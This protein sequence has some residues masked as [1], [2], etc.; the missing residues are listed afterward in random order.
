[1]SRRANVQCRLPL[2]KWHLISLL[3]FYIH[4]FSI[5]NE[6]TKFW[7]VWHLG[8][9]LF[10]QL[11]AI[12]YAI[13]FVS[14]R[15]SIFLVSRKSSA[16]VHTVFGP[17][18]A[19]C[20]SQNSHSQCKWKIQFSTENNQE[21]KKLIFLFQHAISIV[22]SRKTVHHLGESARVKWT[23]VKRFNA[24]VCSYFAVYCKKMGS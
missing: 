4:R 5:F 9:I 7:S 19:R 14:N 3:G 18:C 2:L 16:I 22:I 12:L 10:N 13:F 8:M 20:V 24:Y 23:N 21:W 15:K 1:M 17:F 6:S 11:Y